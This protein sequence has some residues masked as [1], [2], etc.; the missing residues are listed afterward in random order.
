MVT[1][2][3]GFYRILPRAAIK[4]VKSEKPAL[5]SPTKLES[6]G[7]CDAIT[8][9]AYNVENL[10]PNSTH[11]GAIASHIVTYLKSPDLMFLQEVQD[12]NG[13]TN[14]A[15]KLIKTNQNRNLR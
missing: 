10:A 13:P 5:P 14:D 3:F 2:A 1:Y 11:M 4:T 9:G 6:K 7:K 12:D 8:F 15:G